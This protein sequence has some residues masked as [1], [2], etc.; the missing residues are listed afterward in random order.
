VL[1]HDIQT[2][3]YPTIYCYDSFFGYQQEADLCLDMTTRGRFT[4]K[5]MME[6]VTFLKHFIDKHTSSI[7][8]PFQE[9]VTSSVEESSSVESKPLA[10]LDLTLESSPNHE[11]RRK[12]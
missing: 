1:I 12:E 5:T 9:K 6:Q 3:L 7:I 4:Y 8:K 11:H 2:C 10:F